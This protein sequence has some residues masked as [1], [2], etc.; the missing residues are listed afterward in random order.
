MK[1]LLAAALRTM[2]NA[3]IAKPL[4]FFLLKMAARRSET[5]IDDNGVLFV[6]KA[7]DGDVEGTRDALKATLEQIEKEFKKD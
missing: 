3:V 6:Q 2:F 7:F 5:L 4:I 1:I